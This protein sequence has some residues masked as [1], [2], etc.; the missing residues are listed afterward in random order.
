MN[1]VSEDKKTALTKVLA[2]LGF[3][4]VVIFAVWL[5]VQIVRVIPSAFSSLASIAEVVYNYRGEEELEVASEK[6]VANS[7]ET[8]TITWS[9]MRK[10]GTYAFSYEC[11]EGVSIDIRKN[12]SDIEEIA[13][14][15]VVELGNSTS[16]EILVSSEKARF[17]DIAYTVRFTASGANEPTAT[18]SSVVTIVNAS[19]PATGVIV[20]EPQTEDDSETNEPEVTTPAPKPATPVY[21]P[22]TPK[23]VTK[24]VYLTPVSDPKGKVDLQVTFLGVGTIKN[25]VFIPKTSISTDDEGA[26]QFEIKNIGTK[27]A[28]DWTYKAELP[29]DITYSSK[30]QKAL[31]PNERAVITLGFEGLTKS[32]TET[33]SVEVTAKGDVKSSNDEFTASVK[34]TN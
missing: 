4:A 13:C 5:A 10:D 27:T 6:S 33:I 30:D 2:I 7:G 16:V 23:T 14:D 19:I 18:Q 26:V 20:E 25:G 9:D 11:T 1:Q 31:K 24:Y 21:T 29:A 34:V 3:F 22:T 28:E 32:R 17:T 15:T 12:G 8:F